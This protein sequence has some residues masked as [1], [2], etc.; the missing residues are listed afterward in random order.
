MLVLPESVCNHP[1]I[2]GAHRVLLHSG[3]EGRPF[4]VVLMMLVDIVDVVSLE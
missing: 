3:L 2:I 4:E 1:V